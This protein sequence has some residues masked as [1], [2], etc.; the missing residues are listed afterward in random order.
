MMDLSDDTGRNIARIWFFVV[1]TS[2]FLAVSL[3]FKDELHKPQDLN[4]ISAGLLA[5]FLGGVG[6]HKFYCRK[7]VWAVVFVMFCWTTIPNIIGL[8]EGIIFL[9]ID[10]E[11]FNRSIRCTS[12]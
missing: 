6:A 1:A 9:V 12:L 5:L 11:Q 3:R 8:I 2:I 4:R 7:Y 10:D